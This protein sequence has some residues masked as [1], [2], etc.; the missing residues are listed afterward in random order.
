MDCFCKMKQN[1]IMG[2]FLSLI[3]LLFP[4]RALF[5][6]LP[7]IS[8]KFLDF[9]IR[10]GVFLCYRWKNELQIFFGFF[11][12]KISKNRARYMIFS[13]YIIR[14]PPKHHFSKEKQ[15]EL[16][17]PNCIS[18][19]SKHVCNMYSHF[20]DNINL[21]NSKKSDCSETSPKN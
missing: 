9:I 15:F 8:L 19:N 1:L 2:L 6:F 14:T 3:V 17:N 16:Y 18:T 10:T 7:K 5:F 13:N 21:P 4:P 11:N 12:P 20:R